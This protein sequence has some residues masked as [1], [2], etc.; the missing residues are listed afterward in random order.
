MI[1]S[2]RSKR[3]IESQTFANRSRYVKV[4]DA[5]AVELKKIQRIITRK[6]LKD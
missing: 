4:Y 1:S 6:G 5:G 2:R 3:R